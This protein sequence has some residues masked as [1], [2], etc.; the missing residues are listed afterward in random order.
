M[1]FTNRC[2]GLVLE[3]NSGSPGTGM[4][5]PDKVW[6][7]WYCVYVKHIC[8]CECVC[9][10]TL[11]VSVC[12]VVWWASIQQRWPAKGATARPQTRWKYQSSA[13]VT[14]NLRIPSLQRRLKSFRCGT[15]HTHEHRFSVTFWWNLNLVSET[16]NVIWTITKRY[17]ING[18]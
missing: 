1:I 9:F 16:Y 11:W 6:W 2:V 13:I 17:I 12:G 8:V 14:E 5:T 4:S 18:W 3:L 7:D 15:T 10:S